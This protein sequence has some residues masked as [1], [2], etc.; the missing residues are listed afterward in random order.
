MAAT[1]LLISESPLTVQ[2]S[3]AVLLGLNE[4][5]FLQQVQYWITR[6]TGICDQYGRRWIYNTVK[7][8]RDQFPFWS[9]STIK[10][11]I[12]SLEKQE[13]LLSTTIGDAFNKTKAYTINYDRIEAMNQN[14]VHEQARAS[15]DCLERRISMP[16]PMQESREHT[17]DR[18][19]FEVA[20]AGYTPAIPVEDEEESQNIKAGEPLEE[21]KM[22]QHKGQND[23]LEEVNLT[24]SKRPSETPVTARVCV[25]SS[26]ARETETTTTENTHR[27]HE[28]TTGDVRSLCVALGVSGA[29]LERFI[30]SYGEAAVGE[31][32]RLLEI[33]MQ[34]KSI[35]NPTGWLHAALRDGYTFTP[36]RPAAQ[37]N[38]KPQK[39]PPHPYVPPA[40]PAVEKEQDAPVTGNLQE[41]LS[42]MEDSSV[43]AK[44]F[45]LRQRG[46]AEGRAS[47]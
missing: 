33:A 47:P 15:M 17:E 12:C 21:V 18:P 2:P 19:A 25:P 22:T 36:V 1:S 38:A 20:E 23:L 9:E 45:L 29:S 34:T 30:R 13:V 6:E 46:N 43:F 7:Q 3:L 11:T 4:A 39:P 40:V 5:I 16:P 28:T 41:A 24:P 32:A 42:R 31:K 26:R 35:R 27:I 10:R 37:E 8:W 14:I 44:E